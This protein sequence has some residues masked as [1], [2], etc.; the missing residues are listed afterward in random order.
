MDAER[1]ERAR[2]LIG[3]HLPKSGDLGCSTQIKEVYV[4]LTFGCNIR[5]RICP[6]WGDTGVCHDEPLHDRYRGRFDEDAMR[7]FLTGARTFDPHTLNISGGEPLLSPHYKTVA[8]IARELEYPQ[9]VLTT[10]AS[11]LPPKVAEA[12]AAVDVLQVSFTDPVEWVRGFSR[13][14]PDGD[15]AEGLRETFA[16][17]REANPDLQIVVNYALERDSIASL[18]AFVDEAL[19]R[20]ELVDALR[21]IHPMYLSPQG[22]AAHKRDLG[23][24]GTDGRFWEGFGADMTGTDVEALRATLER[25][26]TKHPSVMA[27]PMVEPEEL[28]AW[29][30]DASFLPERY[31]DLC[32][33]PWTQ[34]HV[35]P[36]GDVWACYDVV[37]GNIHDD[38]VDHI[39][40][41]SQARKL[42]EHVSGEG[43]F[44]GCSGCFLKY[45][46]V[47]TGTRS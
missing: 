24:F 35:V 8:R 39:W 31:G 10:N 44:G 20:P 27:F 21:L 1:I 4:M 2:R 28:D 38:D 29:Y 11:F 12:A 34:L 45:S 18:E 5:C 47:E 30:G 22:L 46:V 23:R 14:R 25:V 17:A 32:G 7:R 36:N 3:A 9:V 33:A 42:R 16:A 6:F 19:T 40:N 41:G 15:W 26:T 43:L 13:N 37:L